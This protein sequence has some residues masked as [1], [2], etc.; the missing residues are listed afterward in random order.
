LKSNLLLELPTWPLS[1]I[2]KVSA[3]R[4]AFHYRKS[5]QPPAAWPL[6]NIEKDLATCRL[7]AFHY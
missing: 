4:A 1:I 7:A 2:E 3:T 5:L 6:S